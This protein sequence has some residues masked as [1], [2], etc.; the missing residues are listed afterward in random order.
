M[1][2]NLPGY[3]KY[4]TLLLLLYV[5]FTAK[6]QVVYENPKHQIYEF[7]SRQAQKGN[8]DFDDLIQ[9]VSRKQI[10]MHLVSLQDS[11]HKLSRIER[12]ELEFYQKE[13]SEF[14][15]Q[16]P[17]STTFLKKDP[18]GRLRFL[19]VKKG[20]F[21]LRGD[22][23]LFFGTTRS[24]DGTA[25]KNGA[26]IQF[27][28]HGSKNISFQAY[29][30]DFTERGKGFDSVRSFTSEPGIV[31]TESTNR[32]ILNYSDFRGNITY[33]WSNGA[34]SIG[35]D[36]LLYGYG[37]SGRMILSD[38]SPAYPFIRLDYKPLKW[39]SFNYTHAFLQSN[40][41]DSTR[42]YSKGNDVYG[43]NREAYVPKY[44]AS[45]SLTFYP[46]KG[47]SLS[48]GE[49][50]IYSDKLEAGY[51]FPGMFFKVY[52]QYASRYKITTGSNAQFFFQ[53][54]SRNHLKN[55]HLY[56][57][58][59]I[60]EIR[61]SE[62]FNSE[63]SRNQLGFNFGASVTD[64]GI[65][66]LTIGAEYS[67]IN[68]FVYNNLIPAQTYTNQNYTLGDWMGANAD[69]L[70]GY[71]KYTPIPKLKTTL[72]V[73]NTRKGDVGSIKDQ[74]LAEPQPKFLNSYY[75]DVFQVQFKVSY[76][77]LNN[78]YFDA[79]ALWNDDKNDAY[80][81]DKKLKQIQVSVRLGI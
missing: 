70:M 7:L 50:M 74:Y 5:G 51:L 17:D 11:V 68:P 60:D 12:K 33:S 47:L 34:F 19:S 4:T 3:I 48:M 18:A 40:V 25:Y 69:R 52:D 55:T 14:N 81:G 38:K 24:G 2:L 23:S 31:R 44:M 10:A 79:N 63:K 65:P 32:K 27:W 8:I 20:D 54:S 67:R 42:T 22:P 66:Y 78:L 21:L 76:E 13:F 46:I 53:A 59:F 16:L 1:N 71:V 43:N 75:R 39:L 49:S 45:H 73:Q 41:I 57:T 58:L 56:A 72:T 77:W 64:P 62:A 30:Q 9:P 61:M 35:Q 15:A 37:E 80:P 28:G 6:A 29:F 36:Q 26:G